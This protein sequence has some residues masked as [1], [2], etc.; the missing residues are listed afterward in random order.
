MVG[1]AVVEGVGR[2][3]DIALVGDAGIVVVDLAADSLVGGAV[4]EGVG[5]TTKITLFGAA[6]V[7]VVDIAPD[8]LVGGAVDSVVFVV[9]NGKD[10]LVVVALSADLID[11]AVVN[12]SA[13][14]GG[15]AVDTIVEGCKIGSDEITLEVGEAIVDTTAI[16]VGG[17][18]VETSAAAEVVEADKV[19]TD[20]ILMDTTAIEVGGATVETSAVA[21]VV[22]A[23]K[24]TTDGI[25]V[26]RVA[27]AEVAG[28][29]MIA[30]V[31]IMGVVAVED[32]TDLVVSDKTVAL[33]VELSSLGGLVKVSPSSS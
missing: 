16:E 17:A 8:S 6:D 18:T 5:G 26:D 1:G 22:E 11:D 7:V 29:V 32:T 13:I 27:V 9:T 15:G 14:K 4:V 25:L 2:A 20:G 10:V 3:T 24:V 23:D 12:K 30:V 33:T 19:T 21:E 28:N 31:A